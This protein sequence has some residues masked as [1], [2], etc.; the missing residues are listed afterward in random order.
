MSKIK[1]MKIVNLVLL[2]LV[3][4]Q[5]AG[6]EFY[7]KISPTLF[8][9]GHKRAAILIAIFIFIHLLT[10]WKWIKANYLKRKK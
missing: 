1:T 5:L 3:I 4:N 9:W 2:I 8:K 6:G 7:H 10:N